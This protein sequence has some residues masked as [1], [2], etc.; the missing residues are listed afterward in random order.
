MVDGG[1]LQA[2]KDTL[3]IH[4]EATWGDEGFALRLPDSE[5]PPRVDLIALSPDEIEDLVIEQVGTSPLFAA[6]FR[7]N[8]AR[9]LLLPRRRPG[10]RTPLWQQRLRAHDLQQV[11]VKYASFPIVL[12]TYREVLSDVFELPAL[13]ELLAGIGRGDV[14]L[15]RWSRRVPRRSPA[16]CCSA[17]PPLTCTRAT[18]RWPSAGRRR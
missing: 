14:R 4:V 11:A 13:R 17:T 9:A 5:A 2:L 18:R 15:V 1:D 6:R 10:Q 16:R 3:G 8:A 7:E 12:E